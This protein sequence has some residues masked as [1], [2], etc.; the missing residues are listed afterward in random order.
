MRLGQILTMIMCVNILFAQGVL[1]EETDSNICTST[2]A[3]ESA[4]TVEDVK[5]FCTSAPT[6]VSYGCDFK[7]RDI[8]ETDQYKN[9]SKWM[10]TASIIHSY[11]EAGAPRFMP[12]GAMFVYIGKSCDIAGT[13][14]F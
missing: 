12:E 6:G 10:V 5:T 1:A 8:V 9:K 3:I 14:R 7:A 13:S 4:K 2:Q 11:S